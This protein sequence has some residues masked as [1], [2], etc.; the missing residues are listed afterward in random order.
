[1]SNDNTLSKFGLKVGGNLVGKKR[2]GMGRYRPP[3]ETC[4]GQHVM[5]KMAALLLQPPNKTPNDTYGDILVPL[6]I[7]KRVC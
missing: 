1:M 7:E 2:D 6:V 5:L 3:L 4:K